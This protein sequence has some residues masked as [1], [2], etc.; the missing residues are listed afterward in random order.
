LRSLVKLAAR[1]RLPVTAA[2]AAILLG[3]SGG[4][5]GDGGSQPSVTIS[6]RITYD[7]VPLSTS[8]RGLDYEATVAL[9][10]RAINVD[11]VRASDQ[12]VLASTTTDGNGAYSVSAPANTNVFV[13]ARAVSRSAGSPSEP[14]RW[15][16][17]ILNNTNGNA[18]YVLDG[19]ARSTGATAE[20]RDLHAASGWTGS[21]Y[22]ETRAAAPFAVL[23]TLYTAVRFVTEGADSSVDLAPL[24]VF[25]SPQNR[26]SDVW[27]PAEGNIQ[28]TLYRSTALDGFPAGIYVLGQENVDTD[29][30]DGHVVAHEFLHF[31]EDAVS[32]TDTTG[33]PHSLNERLDMRLAFSE[34]FASAFGA[35]VMNDSLVRDSFGDRQGQDFHYDVEAPAH[36]EVAGWFN[37]SSVQ[38]VVWDLYD[39]PNEPHDAVALGFRPLYDVL[40]SELRDETPLTAIFPFVAG[41]KQRPGVPGAAVDSVVNAEAINGSEIEPYASREANSG[42]AASSIDLVLPVYADIALNGPAVRV[43]GSSSIT[44]DDGPPVITVPGSYNKLGNRRFLRF[45]SPGPRPIEIRVTCELSDPT[46]VGTPQPDPDFILSRAFQREFAGT[47]TPFT[48]RLQTNVEAGDYVLEVYDYSHVDPAA[49]IRRGRTCMIVNITG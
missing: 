17:R 35:M 31:L 9:P 22:T 16:L 27:N 15:D 38:A 7:R 49:V 5:G 44:I 4:S 36:A 48:E 37:E 14:A 21:A 26:P 40:V 46:C 10:V 29:E 47:A 18:L 6:G 45:T 32:R 39:G 23:D 41:L 30:Y 25:W 19:P 11:L 2:S 42:V 33:G 12:A 20:T 28:T 13:R 43:C 34:G 24:E 8:G 3:C 1:L